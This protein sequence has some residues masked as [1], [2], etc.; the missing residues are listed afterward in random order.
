VIDRDSDTST[1]PCPILRCAGLGLH[2]VSRAGRRPAHPTP[3][4]ID[5][6][7]GAVGDLRSPI[8]FFS[9]KILRF[10]G[11]W[12]AGVYMGVT[13]VVVWFWLLDLKSALASRI[14]RR[15]GGGARGPSSDAVRL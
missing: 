15:P 12:N 10:C 13:C 4:I 14:P 6:L 11:S 3:M 2:V 8:S 1:S 5:F 9:R 7:A